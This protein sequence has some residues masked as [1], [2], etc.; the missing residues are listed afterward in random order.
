MLQGA[1]LAG[2]DSA[3]PGDGCDAHGQ[4]RKT[5]LDFIGRPLSAGARRRRRRQPSW[6]RATSEAG[7]R[8]PKD[9]GSQ[10]HRRAR[11]ARPYRSV[12][13]VS[14]QVLPP[15]AVP[16]LTLHGCTP[17]QEASGQINFVPGAE[18]ATVG[19]SPR[20]PAERRE[21]GRWRAQAAADCHAAGS[22]PRISVP[23]YLLTPRGA[24][25]LC[26]Y[27]CCC[28][29]CRVVPTAEP[30]EDRSLH[31]RFHLARFRFYLSLAPSKHCPL[32][33]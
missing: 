21:R 5:D 25:S 23:P 30:C 4:T 20:A 1:C 15:S 26:C 6:R 33:I 22:T 29:C 27:C 10:S 12:Q 31:P 18:Q 9:D 17:M 32:P 19:S 14:Q 3:P 13:A 2:T 24:I 8:R 7:P 28:Y 16:R 11:T